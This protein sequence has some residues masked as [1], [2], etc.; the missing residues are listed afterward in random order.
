M[1]AVDGLAGTVL[2]HAQLLVQAI[3]RL[4]GAVFGNAH[5][6]VQAVDGLAGTVLGD[7]QFVVQ[8][9]DGL[10]GA[11]LGHVHFL[12][13][14]IDRLAGTVFGDTGLGGVQLFL[15]LIQGAFGAVLNQDLGLAGVDDRGFLLGAGESGIGSKYGKGKA[16]YEGAFHDAAPERVG[17]SLDTGSVSVLDYRLENDSAR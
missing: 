13:Q 8:A 4:A 16:K 15:A 3:D 17:S 11:I 7:A 12:N 9:V 14:A 10:A 1:Q 6:A 5:L 2:G